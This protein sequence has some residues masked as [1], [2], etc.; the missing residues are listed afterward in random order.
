MMNTTSGSSHD[1][2]NE[3]ALITGAVDLIGTQHAAVL[4]ETSARVIISDKD[5]I[6]LDHAKKAL[7]SAN[8]EDCIIVELL[9]VTNSDNIEVINEKYCIDILVNNAAV[10]PKVDRDVNKLKSSSFENFSEKSWKLDLDVGIVWSFFYWYF[11]SDHKFVTS[12]TFTVYEWQ[13]I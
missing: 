9:D 12:T 5:R 11:S 7:S 1:C 4:L 13:T 2:W 10:D 3:V 6:K 8:P